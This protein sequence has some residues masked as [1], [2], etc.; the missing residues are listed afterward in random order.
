MIALDSGALTTKGLDC[1]EIA[2]LAKN[3]K[4]FEVEPVVNVGRCLVAHAVRLSFQYGSSGRVRIREAL[5]ATPGRPN[6]DPSELYK[7]MGF[8][9]TGIPSTSVEYVDL[10]ISEENAEILLDRRNHGI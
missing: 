9:D 8:L 6:E 5:N 4:N 10:E 2:Y 1:V 7:R 3:P